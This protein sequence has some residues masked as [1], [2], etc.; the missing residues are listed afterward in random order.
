VPRP[1]VFDLF[2]LLNIVDKE[3]TEGPDAK[4]RAVGTGP[5]VFQEWVQ[6]DH[7]DLVKNKNYWQ[8]NRPYLDGIHI[9][10]LVDSQS[11][12]VQ[13]ESGALDALKSPALR[14]FVRFKSDPRFKALIN[15]AT[16][17]FHNM[18]AD[19]TKA[20][21]NS[22][23]LRQALNYAIDRKRFVDTILL[24]IGEPLDLPWPSFSPA[25]DAAKNAFYAFDLDKAR[26]LVKEAG[27]SGIEIDM[28]VQSANPEQ[29]GFAQIYQADLATIGIKINIMNLELA[30]WKDQVNNKKYTGVFVALGGGGQLQPVSLF[31]TGIAFAPSV[32]NQGYTA[33][34]TCAS[35]PRLP[36]NPTRR[37]AYP[38]TPN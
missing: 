21:T 19:V 2:E 12:V 22:K 3:T 14:D 8:P 24:G 31:T 11:A 16:G 1:A 9:V 4:L 18:G 13:F 34:S 5:F 32:N 17:S 6:G 29:L 27:A 26:A 7:L 20:P 37:N 35:L 10:T 28:R 36:A 38:C 33:L 25:Y 15:P 23:T 30:T